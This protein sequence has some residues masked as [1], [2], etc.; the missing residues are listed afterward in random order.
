MLTARALAASAGADVAQSAGQQPLVEVE[1][2]AMMV[3]PFGVSVDG[4]EDTGILGPDGSRIG[5]VDEGP[6]TPEGR[7]TAVSAEMGGFLGA[8]DE[9]AI[10]EPSHPARAADGLT[11]DMTEERVEALPAWDDRGP[12][13]RRGRGALHGPPRFRS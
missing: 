4:F 12:R 3:E 2:K 5:E 6:T 13:P 7:I 8:G 11:A 1:D 10:L 9:E